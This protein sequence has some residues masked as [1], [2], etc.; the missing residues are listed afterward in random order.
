VCVYVYIY[1]CVCVCVFVCYVCVC[2]YVY[3]LGL[4]DVSFCA[5]ANVLPQPPG[6]GMKDVFWATCM[7]TEFLDNCFSLYICVC[8]YIYIYIYTCT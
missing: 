1:I 7:L 4:A 5:S 2:L 6:M 3:N 8:V